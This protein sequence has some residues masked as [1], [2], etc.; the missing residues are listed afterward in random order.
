M[1]SHWTPWPGHQ[2]LRGHIHF[3][4]G[5]WEW[6]PGFDVFPRVSGRR[7]GKGLL[8][9]NPIE[10]PIVGVSKDVFIEYH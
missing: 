2:R 4:A 6:V 5:E 7:G 9:S 10:E 1:D 8:L 3:P